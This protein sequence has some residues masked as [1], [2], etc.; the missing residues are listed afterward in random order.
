MPSAAIE[1]TVTGTAAVLPAGPAR[2]TADWFD[3]RRELGPH[4]YKH[5]PPAV[6]Y[7]LAAT[8]RALAATRPAEP[9]D[10]PPPE[11]YGMVVGTSNA[12][13][14]LHAAMDRT[15][16]ATGSADL[17]PALA[18][19]F[20]VNLG[21]GRLAAE[22]S[23][24]G[25]HVTL[26]TTR[27]AGLEAIEVAARALALGRADTLLAGVTEEVLDPA[28]P[29][30]PCSE[31]GA[32]MLVVRRPVPGAEHHGRCRV[33]T[34]FMPPP[35][36]AS[37]GRVLAAAITAVGGRGDHPVVAVLDSSRIGE[38]IRAELGERARLRPAG[39]GC[40]APLA[41]VAATLRDATK[42]TIVISAAAQGNLA[43][44]LVTPATK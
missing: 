11:R 5:L 40:L 37:A 33:R 28:E 41:Q 34:A 4:G 16:V 10:A 38:A 1:I 31:S 24:K 30:A 43:V 3:Y 42:P 19:Y 9:G 17:S 15:V 26:T 39:A 35:A 23:L 7:L 32:V 44:A 20:S 12:V 13:A 25:F 29:G 22:H 8:R 6:R 27:V 2:A 21:G 18:P 36:T 14:G